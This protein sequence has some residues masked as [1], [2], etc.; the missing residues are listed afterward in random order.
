MLGRSAQ[1]KPVML[2]CAGGAQAM[3]DADQ[4]RPFAALPTLS[5]ILD[6]ATPHALHDYLRALILVRHLCLLT[7]FQAEDGPLPCFSALLSI[8]FPLTRPAHIPIGLS[9]GRTLGLALQSL[10]GNAQPSLS[11]LCEEPYNTL[12]LWLTPGRG[13]LRCVALARCPAVPG[14]FP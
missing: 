13:D 3:R 2:P 5:G 14:P 1:A 6:P 11:R 8:I 9:A 7:L 4:E 12:A 10:L